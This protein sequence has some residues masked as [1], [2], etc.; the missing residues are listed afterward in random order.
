MDAAMATDAEQRRCCDS[1]ET[2]S[3]T[4][5][6]PRQSADAA[7]FLPVRQRASPTQP[8]GLGHTFPGSSTRTE[9]P[10]AHSMVYVPR[11]RQIHKVELR[12]VLL[13]CTAV[14][15]AHALPCSSEQG[16]TLSVH[17]PANRVQVC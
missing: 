13:A 8:V 15:P 3:D 2:L 4:V 7:F 11:D 5:I 1:T 10:R 9:I 17:L 6:L 12:R 14:P 16:Q